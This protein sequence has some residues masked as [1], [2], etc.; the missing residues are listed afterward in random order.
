M[1]VNPEIVAYP[2]SSEEYDL[3]VDECYEDGLWGFQ[4]G[5]MKIMKLDDEDPPLL[6]LEIYP[7]WL[8]FMYEVLKGYCTIREVFEEEDE[9]ELENLNLSPPY[10]PPS[11]N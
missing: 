4:I 5:K 8:D 11:D 7:C 3:H 2:V 9:E 1:G 6:K 10:I